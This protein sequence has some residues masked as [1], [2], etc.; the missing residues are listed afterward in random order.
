M[1]GM[2]KPRRSPGSRDQAAADRIGGFCERDRHG[3]GSAVAAAPRR[4]P[5]IV[6][7]RAAHRCRGGEGVVFQAYL[8]VPLR[9]R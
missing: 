5:L 3:G 7:P 4:V 9:R 1:E 6:N 2:N 8:T